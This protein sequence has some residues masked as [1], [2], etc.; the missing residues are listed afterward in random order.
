MAQNKDDR[1][2]DQKERFIDAARATGARMSKKEFSRV[3][4][5]IAKAKPKLG[6]T[7]ST[8]P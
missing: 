4:G 1:T 2:K 7:R 3:L 5:K 8:K 6:K